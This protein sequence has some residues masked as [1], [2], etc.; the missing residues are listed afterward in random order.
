LGACPISR[1]KE[2]CEKGRK[3]SMQ[4]GKS[5]CEKEGK[6]NHIRVR[7]FDKG[8]NDYKPEK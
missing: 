8:C 2:A 1:K 7:V 3:R 5:T 4:E 6:P